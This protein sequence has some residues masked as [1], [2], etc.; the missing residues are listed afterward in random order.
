MLATYW[1]HYYAPD[2]ARHFWKFLE[3][4]PPSGKLFGV[5]K[6]IDDKLAPLQVTQ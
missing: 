1:L 4:R 5:G 6:E 3:L 2:K